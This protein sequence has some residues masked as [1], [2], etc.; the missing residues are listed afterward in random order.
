MAY[1]SEAQLEKNLHSQLV[2]Q[3]YTAVK[4]PDYDT[5]LANF[6]NQLNEFNKHKLAG[7]SLTDK[8]FRRILTAIEDK[9]IYDSAK[10]L[11]DKLL[12]ERE[13][14]SELYVELLNTMYQS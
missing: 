11:R 8:E 9:S 10:I 3:G 2:N 1:Q 7:Q 13:D 14:G 6:R 5:L 4:I 12:I